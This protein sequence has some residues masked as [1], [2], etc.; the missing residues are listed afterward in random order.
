MVS[1]L[2]PQLQFASLYVGDLHPEVTESILYDTFSGVGQVASC[3][4]CRDNVSRRS[5]GYGYVNFHSAEDAEKAIE[6]LNYSQIK[7][8]ACR[9]MWSQRDPDKRK[10]GAS[11]IFVKNLD[12][13]IDNKTLHDTFSIFG[14]ILSCKVATDA[15]GKS[16]GYG[17]VHYESEDAAKQAIEKVNG[18]QIGDKTVFVGPFLKRDELEKAESDGF[19]NLYV[20]HLPEHWDD[21]SLTQV[22]SEFGEIATSVIMSNSESRRFALVNFVKSESAQKAIAGLHGKPVADFTSTS[23]TEVDAAD[24]EAKENTNEAPT[25]GTP[26]GSFFGAISS[27]MN[28]P[29]KADE[30]QK[31]ED[32]TEEKKAGEDAAEQEPKAAESPKATKELQDGDPEL[33]LYVQRAQT[34][35]E[36]Q[37]ELQS[38]FERDGPKGGGK[39]GRDGRGNRQQQNQQ[40]RGVK[41]YIKNLTEEVDDDALKKLFEEYG[42]I[43]SANSRKDDDGKCRGVGFVVFSTAEEAAKAVSEMH[44]KAVNGKNLHVSLA[45]KKSQ[46]KERLEAKGD[47][48]GG[49]G[50]RGK[51]KALGA[52][53]PGAPPP[54]AYSQFAG[55][56]LLPPG[57]PGAP[58]VP[59]ARPPGAGLPPYPHPFALLPP[60]IRPPAGAF[61]YGLPPGMAPHLHPAMAAHLAGRPP[62]PPPLPGQPPPPPMSHLGPPGGPPLPAGQPPPPPMPHLGAASPA[63]FRPPMGL[64]QNPRPLTAADLAAAPVAMQKQMLGERLYP[65]VAKHNSELAGKITGM[66]IELDISE[67]L[68]LLESDSQLKRKVD[69]AIKVLNSKR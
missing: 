50:D 21:G 40:P 29:K 68:V 15:I 27:F 35:A 53:P 54:M 6:R 18:M 59:L 16:K 47:K 26:L 42:N 4:V 9:I 36:R 12:D 55:A 39:G 60:G 25:S 67:L 32:E 10:G 61:P 48:G 3:R 28:S 45:E 56:P 37:A 20:K 51:G 13:S 2:A 19:T 7:G 5:L 44:Q 31:V 64:G 41:L 65:A 52:S 69:E 49:K 17:F 14:N 33:F 8:K 34:K 43:I 62:M 1:S 63:G 23:K 58:G 66:M 57:I 22:F 11:N 38:R 46:R 24:A 30:T